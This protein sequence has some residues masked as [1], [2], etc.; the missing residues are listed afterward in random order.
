M[1]AMKNRLGLEIQQKPD[2]L[3]SDAALDRDA[4]DESRMRRVRRIRIL[5]YGLLNTL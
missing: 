4:A 3:R 2:E 1:T 5:R